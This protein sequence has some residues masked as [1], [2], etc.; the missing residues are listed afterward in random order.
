MESAKCLESMGSAKR[1]ALGLTS[2]DICANS[3]AH[4]IV[5][6]AQNLA[7]L[8]AVTPYAQNSAKRSACCAWKNA[9]ISVPIQSA[10]KDALSHAIGNLVIY[11]AK[12]S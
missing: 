6:H 3:I 11:L 9:K 1:N 8:S 12:K 7:R 2:A 10:L 5:R 4:R